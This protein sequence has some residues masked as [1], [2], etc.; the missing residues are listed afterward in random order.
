M[1]QK[2]L[3]DVLRPASYPKK[4]GTTGTKFTKVGA[5]FHNE[6][7]NTYSVVM[8]VE[9]PT[10]TEEGYDQLSISRISHPVMMPKEKQSDA[11][12]A[13]AAPAKPGDN[14]PA[15]LEDIPF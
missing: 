1:A 4:D 9:S 3:G 13:P 2:Y 6:E 8:E 11:S 7:K 12:A 15:K 5:L 10:K 14:A